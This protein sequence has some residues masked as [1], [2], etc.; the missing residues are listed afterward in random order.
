MLLLLLFYLLVVDYPFYVLTFPR[1]FK[2]FAHFHVMAE[3]HQG[4]IASS[5]AAIS[6]NT[7]DQYFT[8]WF[9]AADADKN[10]QISG[11]E[12][13]AFFTKFDGLV[14]KDLV[15]LWEIADEK[16]RGF[17]TMRE[18]IVACGV[19]SLKQAGVKEITAAHVHLLRN[20]ETR[21]LPTP[22]LKRGERVVVGDSNEAAPASRAAT[23]TQH[24]EENKTT[25]S[26]GRPML[27]D[28]IFAAYDQPP[29][30]PVVAAGGFDGFGDAGGGVNGGFN[31]APG[32]FS[33]DA[34]SS[35]PS[36]SVSV[37][38]FGAPLPSV[39]V[40]SDFNSG[41]DSNFQTSS[42]SRA[43][44]STAPVPPPSAMPPL[45]QKWPA[46]GPSDYQRY[47]IQFL[48][49]TNNDPTASIPAQVC[50][51]MIAASGLEKHVLKQVWEIADARKIGALAWP[52]FVVGMYLAD[53]MKTRGAQ[54]PEMM[55]PMPFP[56]FDQN[57]AGLLTNIAPSISM[58]P[59][60]AAVAAPPPPQQQ[61]Q[62]QQQMLAGIQAPVAQQDTFNFIP[63]S[64]LRDEFNTVS[65]TAST[66][67][68]HTHGDATFTFRGPQLDLSAVPDAERQ[69]A[70]A[71][72][73]AAKQADENLFA[74]ETKESENKM[75]AKAAQEALGNLALFRR[76]CE[77]NLAEAENKAS[78]AESEAKELKKKVEEAMKMCEELIQKSEQGGDASI[79]KRLEK[80]REERDALRAQLEE[81]NAKLR[82]LSGNSATSA[83]NTSEMELEIENTEKEVAKIKNDI[84]LAQKRL[85]LASERADLTTQLANVS[86]AAEEKAREQ[87]SPHPQPSAMTPNGSWGGVQI[88]PLPPMPT[89]TPPTPETAKI[90]FDKWNEW[91]ATKTPPVGGK[92]PQQ[93]KQPQ[94]QDDL[95]S[96]SPPVI[97]PASVS[98]KPTQQQQQQQPKPTDSFDFSAPTPRDFAPPAV[99][100]ALYSQTSSGGFFSDDETT[101][102]H[103]RNPSGLD[104]INFSHTNNAATGGVNNGI[105]PSPALFN[106]QQQTGGGVAKTPENFIDPFAV[107]DEGD[108]DVEDSFDDPFA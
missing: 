23:E 61:Q 9:H 3:H 92:P 32:T 59:A 107:E 52:E 87:L 75:S 34:F 108:D 72:L 65:A 79:A 73:D 18:F 90:G 76:K 86:V 93:K 30:V 67:S 12:A 29:G 17:L 80:A 96:H 10:N 24:E 62:Q 15:E 36:S 39:S 63:G 70:E 20:G 94:L 16:K 46:M 91:D 31:T 89:P 58:A 51:P 1:N 69:F 41:F 7:L 83:S 55:P 6:T 106:H 81:E 103:S 78:V 49:S 50:A 43:F 48:Q 37:G 60:A 66:T 4:T 99:A 8:E 19:V 71:Q 28:D 22:V 47:Q 56:P 84:A 40:S 11:N 97:P 105:P 45:P 68:H 77:A 14:K 64:Q 33:A 5:P 82:E 26:S 25:T 53:V 85:Q 2:P 44:A 57:A 88:P 102:N 104:G 35:A 74:Q 42:S 95:F 38:G 100:A 101:P 13:V 21:G 54:C 98:T 27:S